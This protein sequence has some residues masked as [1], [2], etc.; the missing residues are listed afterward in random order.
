MTEDTADDRL[1]D[2]FTR[3]AGPVAEDGRDDGGR[4][5]DAVATDEFD[6]GEAD[7][8]ATDEA[9]LDQPSGTNLST[10]VDLLDRQLDG[11]VPPGRI[12]ALMAPPDTQSELLVKRLVAERNSLYLSTLRPEWE[13]EEE[14]RDHV[15]KAKGPEAGTND[16]QVRE[17][18]PEAVVADPDD[19]LAALDKQ[20]ML[21][22]DA[23]NEFEHEDRTQYAEFLNS[24]KKRLWQTGSVGLMYGIEESPL[25]PA[26][27]ITLRRAD[28]V[29][30]LRIAVDP[31]A[32]SYN[33]IVSK[34][35]G[36]Q[37]P[38]EPIKLTLTDDV[39]I[40]TSRDIA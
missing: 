23:A 17:V 9:A 38:T 6:F 12:V 5:A 3:D 37:A 29:W 10:G 35:R 40:D 18:S 34:V 30:Q 14:L 8:V 11:G 39:R 28:L 25:P 19:V 22:V 20:S 33:L 27:A 13:I 36:G 21:V 24:V 2:L 16:V 7:A 1:S 32:I 26:R 31:E 4:E 15:Q